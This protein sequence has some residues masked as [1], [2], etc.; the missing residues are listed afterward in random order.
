MT[1]KKNLDHHQI[2]SAILYARRKTGLHQGD[3]QGRQ[4]KPKILHPGKLIFNTKGTGEM[5]S[6]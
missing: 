4:C 5:L 6:I 2:L 3:T 1:H